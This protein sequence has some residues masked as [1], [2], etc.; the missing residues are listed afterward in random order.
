MYREERRPFKVAIVGGGLSLRGVDLDGLRPSRSVIIG[1]NSVWK[2]YNRYDSL[3]TIDTVNLDKRF[4]GCKS[5]PIVAVPEAFGTPRA[6]YPCDRVLP[7]GEFNFIR[8]VTSL[9][10]SESSDE[11]H[12]G[13]NSSYGALNL[14]YHMKP[15]YI[16]MFG[17]DLENMGSYWYEHNDLRPQNHQTNS[18][19]PD[20]FVSTI[21]QLAAGIDV[22]NCSQISK[23]ACFTK[24]TAE[25]GIARWNSV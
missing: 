4:S 23:I 2:N 9:G 5:R 24:I 6:Q 25:E 18:R 15:R 16:F 7:Q 12:G 11:I 17:I 20:N 21:Y 13:E 10:L 14:A 8:R 1:L 22:I 19:V 3:F